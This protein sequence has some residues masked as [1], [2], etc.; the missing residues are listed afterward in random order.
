MITPLLRVLSVL[1]NTHGIVHRDIKPEN[2]FLSADGESLEG[3]GM[4]SAGRCLRSSLRLL[5]SVHAP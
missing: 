2:I 3:L 4:C 1:H 5:H